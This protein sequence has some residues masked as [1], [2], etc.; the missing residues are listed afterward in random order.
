M[1]HLTPLLIFNAKSTKKAK[2]AKCFVMFFRMFH[3]VRAFRIEK[4]DEKQV[5]GVK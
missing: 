1:I 4:N 2:E 3:S 5:W